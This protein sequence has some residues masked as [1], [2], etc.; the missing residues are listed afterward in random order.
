[1]LTQKLNHPEEDLKLSDY[2]NSFIKGLGQASFSISGEGVFKGV[3]GKSIDAY[4]D[5]MNLGQGLY[6]DFV[7]NKIK[8]FF[9]Y[10]TKLVYDGTF[11]KIIDRLFSDSEDSNQCI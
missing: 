8:W 5:E 11:S 2:T 7:L 4:I 10:S 9:N 6:V 3:T 1:M